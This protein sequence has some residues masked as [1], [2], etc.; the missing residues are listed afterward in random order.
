[1]VKM[2][3]RRIHQL[4]TCPREECEVSQVCDSSEELTNS[5]GYSLVTLS[6]AQEGNL[7]HQEAPVTVHL[8][9]PACLLCLHQDVGLGCGDLTI[10]N[11]DIFTLHLLGSYS[12]KCEVSDYLVTEVKNLGDECSDAG[13]DE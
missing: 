5:P 9:H 10:F 4:L 11:V 1:M 8:D 12:R 13:G 3:T 2:K 7:R 6:E